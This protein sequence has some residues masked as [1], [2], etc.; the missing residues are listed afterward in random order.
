[1]WARAFAATFV[2]VLAMV[3][4]VSAIMQLDVRA[5]RERRDR[6]ANPP[7]LLDFTAAMFQAQHGTAFRPFEH[8]RTICDA[9]ERVVNGECKRLIINVTPSSGK[10][11]LARS[12]IAWCMGRWP[13]SEFIYASYSDALATANASEARSSMQH[14]RFAEFFG[15]PTFRRDVNAKGEFKT[16]QGGCVYAAGVGG[17]LTGYHAG[18]MREG[19]GG[20]IFIDDWIK[21]GEAQSEAVR[22]G[23]VDWFKGTLESRVNSPDTPVVVIGQRS[24]VAD[25]AGWLLAGGNEE[26]WD[27]VCIPALGA[28]GASFCPELYPVERLLRIKGGKEVAGVKST[29]EFVFAA[30]YQ[31]S[32][33]ILGGNIIKGEWFGRYIMP[34][35]LKW[36][37]I[38]ADT[39]GKTKTANDY[40]VFS[41]W[42][43]GEDGKLYLLDLMRG[44]WEAMELE[45]RAVAFWAKHADQDVAELGALRYL[46]VEDASSGTGLIQTLRTKGKAPII[47]VH[48][49]R[50]KFSRLFDVLGQMQSGRVVIPAD[51]AFVHDFV[52]ECEA[53]T[54]DDTHAND[55]Q[56]DTLIDAINDM[57]VTVGPCAPAARRKA[58]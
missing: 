35:K 38:F 54:D 14:E 29:G 25:L 6:A 22:Q 57:L 47:G 16:T 5:E 12:F 32:P 10:T 51:A 8:Q 46:K 17:T 1:M 24:H 19:F 28:D 42:G 23:V 55:D 15:A 52:A 34:P 13:D 41:A 26:E 43:L 9:L 31:Q 20:A 27:H 48:H 2:L 3:T 36:R 11:E 49:S 56:V 50:D 39:A 21:M 45:N 40:T 53:M 44:K 18:K 30:Q 37:A 58:S 7:S 4:D 33:K